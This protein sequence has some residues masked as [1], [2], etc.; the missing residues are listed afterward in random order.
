MLFDS[1][2]G[3][4]VRYL[5]VGGLAVNAHGYVRNTQDVDLIIDFEAGNLSTGLRIL[6]SMGYAPKVPVAIEEFADRSKRESW[7]A[8]KQ[9]KVF[10]LRSESHRETDVDVFVRDPLGFEAAY[11]RASYQTLF[12]GHQS[13]EVAAPEVGRGGGIRIPFCS[14]DDLVKLKLEAGRPRDL[15]DL[16]RLR[17]SRGE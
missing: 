7:I 10:G 15:E 9:M 13:P 8:E 16:R 12:A 5:V 3:S 6:K 1:L 17:I 11:R 14:Y 4:G 2:N